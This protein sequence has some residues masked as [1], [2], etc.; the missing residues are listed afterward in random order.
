[1]FESI[2]RNLAVAA[3]SLALIQGAET[4]LLAKDT[5][6]KPD[7][8]RSTATQDARRVSSVVRQ[9]P[10]AVYTVKSGDSL[11]VIASRFGLNQYKLTDWVERTTG[12][13]PKNLQVGLVLRLADFIQDSNGIAISSTYTVKSGETLGGIVGR[14]N[15]LLKDKISV[16][17]IRFFN[18]DIVKNSNQIDKGIVLKIPKTHSF[19]EI[20]KQIITKF[21]P[22]EQLGVRQ[23]MAKGVIYQK[24]LVDLFSSAEFS[25]LQLEE[26]K[27]FVHL[28]SESKVSPLAVEGLIHRSI[29]GS[30]AILSRD[31]QGKTALANLVEFANL[32]SINPVILATKSEALASIL[33]SF[34]AGTLDQGAYGTCTAVSCLKKIMAEY[35]AAVTNLMLQFATKGS[36]EV[37]TA[38]L[39]APADLSALK[40]GGLTPVIATLAPAIMALQPGMYSC[41]SDTTEILN[42]DG[43]ITKKRGMAYGNGLDTFLGQI[44]GKEYDSWE[45][46]EMRPEDSRGFFDNNPALFTGA[47]VA[48]RWREYTQAEKEASFKETGKQYE[49][50][51]HSVY[52]H[53]VDQ[54]GRV[55]FLNSHNAGNL[56]IDRKF[57]IKNG[58]FDMKYHGDGIW[59]MSREDFHANLLSGLLPTGRNYFDRTTNLHVFSFNTDGLA[60]DQELSTAAKIV[61]VGAVVLIA[62]A[63]F[64]MFGQENVR[65][66]STSAVRNRAGRSREFSEDTSE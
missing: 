51:A 17:D 52:L 8:N 62:M 11:S 64:F 32:K 20:N 13:T 12:Q 45:F 23:L 36:A 4:D 9:E 59:S 63:G 47:L 58:Y 31:W 48:L 15:R 38:K 42:S 7:R 16:E 24:V 34:T 30:P 56:P 6:P 1:M 57:R 39:I 28:L 21:S 40:G 2:K 19:D 18:S 14:I 49:Y 5:A 60:R 3:T 29:N 65:S 37:G 43:T 55:Q 41:S 66:R 27:Q 53:K 54:D 35:P 22:A 61:G 10:P 33:M 44:T 50:G 26:Q 46:Y 25:A